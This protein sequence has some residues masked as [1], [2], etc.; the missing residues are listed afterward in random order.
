LLPNAPSCASELRRP[1]L[2]RT[3]PSAQPAA[4]ELECMSSLM[5]A[6]WERQYKISTSQDHHAIG[7][8]YAQ[9]VTTRPARAARA[10]VDHGSGRRRRERARDGGAAGTGFHPELLTTADRRQIALANPC[11]PASL[12]S[13]IAAIAL[14][15]NCWQRQIG[16][17]SLVLGPGPHTDASRTGETGDAAG[18]RPATRGADSH[19]HRP[20]GAE[21]THRLN[22]VGVRSS[23]PPGRQS[24]RQY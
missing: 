22:T 7:G 5:G 6:T 21:E 9:A 18:H 3:S 14:L 2:R 17:H 4:A 12:S 1:P 24:D 11:G 20:N 16:D 13:P 19:Q 23:G 15:A 10:S 8:L